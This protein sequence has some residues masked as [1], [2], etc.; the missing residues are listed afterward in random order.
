MSVDDANERMGD[1]VDF[2]K[3]D[4]RKGSI[5]WTFEI[6]CVVYISMGKCCHMLVCFYNTN[7]FAW[8]I[9]CSL[10]KT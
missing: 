5:A 3:E 2:N 1:W 7:Y 8:P 10:V 9:V 6:R 4:V